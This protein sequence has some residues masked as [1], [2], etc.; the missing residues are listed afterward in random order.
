MRAGNYD[1][2]VLY[3]PDYCSTDDWVI[4]S[5]ADMDHILSRLLRDQDLEGVW[6]RVEALDTPLHRKGLRGYEGSRHVLRGYFSTT[7]VRPDLTLCHRSEKTR[8]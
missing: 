4:G 5:R 8:S 6:L 1:D 2:F 3:S 7:S